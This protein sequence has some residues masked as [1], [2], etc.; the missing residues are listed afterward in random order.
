MNVVN[1]LNCFLHFKNINYIIRLNIVFHIF[2]LAPP[3]GLSCI[4]IGDKCTPN[5]G[6]RHCCGGGICAQIDHI[7]ISV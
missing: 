5:D 1:I 6:G 2:L 3:G 7:C 4:K